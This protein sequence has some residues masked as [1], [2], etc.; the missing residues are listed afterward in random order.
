MSGPRCA[1]DCVVGSRDEFGTVLRDIPTPSEELQRP[2]AIPSQADTVKVGH[3]LMRREDFLIW[4]KRLLWID[5]WSLWQD[6]VASVVIV[7]VAVQNRVLVRQWEYTLK[8][9]HTAS[10]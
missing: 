5:R 8:I 2:G 4:Q 3:P 1:E 9:F 10:I 6:K 7:C